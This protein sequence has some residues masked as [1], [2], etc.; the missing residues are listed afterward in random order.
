MT[1]DKSVKINCEIDDDCMHNNF[2]MTIT[3]FINSLN[4][5]KRKENDEKQHRQKGENSHSQHVNRLYI[6]EREKTAA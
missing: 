5:K 2:A 4:L 1:Y 6:F 3:L